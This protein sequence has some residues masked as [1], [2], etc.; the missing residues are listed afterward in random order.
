MPF[1]NWKRQARKH[2]EEFQPTR[3]ANLV[4]AGQLDEAL[5]QAAEATHREMC[6]LEDAGFQNH[7]AWEMVREKYL[8]VPEE[9]G[10]FD[11]DEDEDPNAAELWQECV[12]LHSKILSGN[13]EILEMEREYKAKLSRNVTT[14]EL[15]VTPERSPNSGLIEHEATN[16][17]ASG[18]PRHSSSQLGRAANKALNRWNVLESI[19]ARPLLKSLIEFTAVGLLILSAFEM[20]HIGFPAFVATILPFVIFLFMT[21]G[22]NTVRRTTYISIAVATLVCW[23]SFIPSQNVLVDTQLKS[24]SW[25]APLKMLVQGER[26]WT[27]QIANANWRMRELIQWHDADEVLLPVEQLKAVIPKIREA[28][29]NATTWPEEHHFTELL[30]QHQ[31]A[32]KLYELKAIRHSIEQKLAQG[33]NG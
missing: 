21:D 29:E 10:L 31:S 8:F 1:E 7:E 9:E 18:A 22:K 14:L 20:L 24:T 28:R 33:S 12:D 17:S 4:E 11:D 19:F 13:E 15:E 23:S 3:F 25:R 2:W 6:E 16:V 32:L 26:F 27:G 30:I 5:S